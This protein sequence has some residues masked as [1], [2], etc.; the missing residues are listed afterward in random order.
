MWVCM[1]LFKV[2]Y[3]HQLLCRANHSKLAQDIFTI[4]LKDCDCSA[5]WPSNP[6]FYPSYN[7]LRDCLSQSPHDMSLNASCR[8]VTLTINSTVR[9]YGR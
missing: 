6:R 5:W 3:T 4:P 1:L 8:N 2:G 7:Q 9:S